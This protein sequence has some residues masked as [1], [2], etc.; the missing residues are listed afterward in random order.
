MNAI[1]TSNV[2]DC[3]SKFHLLCFNGVVC[4]DQIF[5]LNQINNEPKT[6]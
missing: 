6:N 4:H 3:N 2:G 1:V 5:N